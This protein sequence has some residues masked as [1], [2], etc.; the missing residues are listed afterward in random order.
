MASGAVTGVKL[1]DGAVT[2]GKILDNAV[3]STKLADYAVGT[4]KLVDGSVTPAKLAVPLL[5]SSVSPNFTLSLANTGGGAA[6]TA[7]GPLHTST[8]DQL[9]GPPVLSA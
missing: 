9:R 3:G 2:S 5:L 8:Q 4:T 1:V 6:L 7:Q